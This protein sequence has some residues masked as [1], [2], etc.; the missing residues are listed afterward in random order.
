ML[1]IFPA[2]EIKKLIL[3]G[4]IETESTE[5]PSRKAERTYEKLMILIEKSQIIEE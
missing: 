2:L 3:V 1:S 4:K 5:K